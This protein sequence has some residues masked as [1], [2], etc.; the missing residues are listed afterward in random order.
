MTG[1]AD[2]KQVLFNFFH[3]GVLLFLIKAYKENTLMG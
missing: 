1:L 2:M 3:K